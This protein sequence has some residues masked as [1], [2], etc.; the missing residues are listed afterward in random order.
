MT[1]HSVNSFM[2]DG[3]DVFTKEVVSCFTFQK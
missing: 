3:I 2:V 1:Q